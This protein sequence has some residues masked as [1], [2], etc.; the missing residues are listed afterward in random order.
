MRPLRGSLPAVTVVP[1]Y[2]HRIAAALTVLLLL[3][4]PAAVAAQTAAVAL[5]A[6]G[7][8]ADTVPV[9][10]DPY[11][12]RFTLTNRGADS[13]TYYVACAGLGAA[14]CVSAPRDPVRVAPGQQVVLVV[15]Y[16][17]TRA[18]RGLVVLRVRDPRT[19][20]RASAALLLTVTG[21]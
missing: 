21:S 8:T 9:K 4:A 1:A 19:G 13:A 10:A 17:A 11:R 7:A 16:R 2:A 14:A 5:A 3:L 18:G 6:E 20:A 15:D 12:L